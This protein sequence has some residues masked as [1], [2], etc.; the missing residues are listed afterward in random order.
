MDNFSKYI[1]G[2]K[3]IFIEK[4]QEIEFL[5][6]QLLK[7]DEEIKKLKTLM[8]IPEDKKPLNSWNDYVLYICNDGN[9]R[10]VREIF[11]EI[12]KMETKPWPNDAKTPCSTCSATCGKLF[13]DGKLYKTNDTPTKYFMLLQ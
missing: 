13:T 2:I 12:N 7:K 5:K 8:N 9:Q 3:Q 10:T 11:N 4:D 6:N 1:C